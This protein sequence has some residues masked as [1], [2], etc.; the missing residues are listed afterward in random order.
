MTKKFAIVLA[1][2]LIAVV[3]SAGCI[4]PETPVD[5]VVPADPIVPVDPV[6]PVEPE[7]PVEEYSVMFMLN[8]DDAGAYTAETVKA[9]DTVSRP[10]S[11]SRSGYTFTGWFT[12]ADGGVVYDFTQ[13]VNSDMMLYAQ[14]K[15]EERKS[16][17]SS[18]SHYWGGGVVTN[19]ATC[20]A[21]GLITYTCNCGQTRTEAIP[22]TGEHEWGDW[23]VTTAVTGGD[24]G[25]K[26]RA[27]TNTG[28]GKTD[29][30]TIPALLKDVKCGDK[31]TFAGKTW[32]VVANE[33]DTL[34][35]TSTFVPNSG[36]AFGNSYND[37]LH[38][39]EMLR[40]YNSM[41]DSDK[42]KIVLSTIGGLNTTDGIFVENGVDTI[43]RYIFTLSVEE[44]MMLPVGDRVAEISR[45]GGLWMYPRE[46]VDSSKYVT[47]TMSK[48]MMDSG[49]YHKFYLVD[50]DGFCPI[51]VWGNVCNYRPSL[52]LNK[53]EISTVEV[54]DWGTTGNILYKLDGSDGD[55]IPTDLG[56]VTDVRVNIH[57]ESLVSLIGIDTISDIPLTQGKP[58]VCLF[59]ELGILAAPLSE[60]DD[61]V[62]DLSDRYPNMNFN[63]DYD[64]FL[65]VYVEDGDDMSLVASLNDSDGPVYPNEI[66]T[67]DYN[68]V[69][70][71][72]TFSILE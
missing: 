13:A 62:D 22:A 34:F 15:E 8:Y 39:R 69:T 20:V 53:S 7:L 48:T 19:E 51:E 27:C 42:K 2:F 50:E 16:S 5:P 9:G 54:S 6:T 11:P 35:V 36:V 49:G 67:A 30:E 29:T 18:H 63:S 25:E 66:V 31:V 60:N 24:D 55:A 47:R 56:E 68:G 10:A 33:E 23:D 38:D 40:L 43:D 52:R 57:S 37:G 17:G 21:D 45:Y 32:T 3:C 70:Y 58:F 14:W 28:C 46:L 72:L 44:V 65:Y 26:I 12:A 1:L 4:D 41:P 61:L 71:E 64:I 59:N